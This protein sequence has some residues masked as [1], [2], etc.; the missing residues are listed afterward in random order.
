MTPRIGADFVI[1]KPP[2][3]AAMIGAAVN[4]GANHGDETLGMVD[5][6]I[7]PHL[8]HPDLPEISM[9]GAEKWAAGMQVPCYAIDDQTAIKVMNE[10]I[11]VISEGHWNSLHQ[12]GETLRDLIRLRSYRGSLH[13]Y[14]SSTDR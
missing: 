9:T 2:T 4:T 6:S 12:R 3:G 5:F 7:F 8:G 14:L 11:G 1:W 10:E 13:L